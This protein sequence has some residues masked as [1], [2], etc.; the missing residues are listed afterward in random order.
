VPL[1]FAI[2]SQSGA[3]ALLYLNFFCLCVTRR[4][5]LHETED[6]FIPPL[7]GHILD[8]HEVNAPCRIAS[9]PSFSPRRDHLTLEYKH[10]MCF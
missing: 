8:T 4:N 10:A 5:A 9:L 3:D 2:L 6:L 1:Y 7:D